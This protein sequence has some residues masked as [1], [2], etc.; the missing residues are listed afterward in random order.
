[1]GYFARRSFGSK[2]DKFFD[3]I[4]CINLDSRPDRWAL[5]SKQFSRF[6]LS[7]SVMRIAGIDLRSDPK[8]QEHEHLQKGK[9]SFLANFGCILSHRRI[10]EQA[11]QAGLRNI[12]VFEDD[13]KFLDENCH[14][15][16]STLTALK[17]IHWE[18]FYLGAT[19]INKITMFGEHLVRAPHG[20]LATHAIAYNQCVFDKILDTLPSDPASF[21]QSDKMKVNAID[22]WLKSDIF[23]HNNFYGS[24][25]IMAVQGLQQSDISNEKLDLE[26]IQ[27]RMFEKNLLSVDQDQSNHVAEKIECI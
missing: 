12:L 23:D 11:R 5:A 13:V 15:V 6:G 19:Y 21:I 25:P 2:L 24:N 14:M 7:K 8:L 9:Y 3:Q 17:E 4:F 18:I 1:M 27:L 22:A 16:G 26:N 10:I 20:A